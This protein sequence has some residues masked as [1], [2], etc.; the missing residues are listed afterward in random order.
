MT[1]VREEDLVVEQVFTDVSDSVAFAQIDELVKN[2][3]VC[4]KLRRFLIFIFN[5]NARHF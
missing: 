3:R 5:R 1:D 2:R 4:Y